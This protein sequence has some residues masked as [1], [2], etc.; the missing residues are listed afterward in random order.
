M[1]TVSKAKVISSAAMVSKSALSAGADVL[2]ATSGMGSPRSSSSMPWRITRKPLPPA[3][4]TPAFFST[5]F[6]LMVSAR[7]TWP[8]SMAASSTDSAAFVL[9]GGAGGPGGGQAGDGED[10]ALGGLHHRL[11]GG[12]H[13]EVQGDG[14][15]PAV[16]GL[17]VLDRLGKAAEQQGQ[18]DAGVAPGAPQQGGGRCLGRLSHGGA[19]AF[20]SAPRRRRRW[21]G[22]YW[23]RCPRRGRGIRSGR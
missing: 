9:P 22:S 5:G 23:C 12:G 16:D 4:T 6:W 11:I 7:A 14:Q 3:S 20:S 8:S 10:G 21:S 15:I 13:A 18:D 1:N 2:L 19:A 17:L